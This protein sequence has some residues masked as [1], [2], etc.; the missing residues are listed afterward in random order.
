MGPDGP[1]WC[2]QGSGT[3]DVSRQKPRDVGAEEGKETFGET[4]VR[5]DQ[6]NQL[7][8]TCHRA[9]GFDLDLIC[10]HHSGPRH[11]MAASKAG[12][13][14]APDNAPKRSQIPSC[15][16]GGYTCCTNRVRDSSRESSMVAGVHEQTH[17]PD[18]QDQEL[19][20]L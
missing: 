14:S 15:A 11:E 13:M 18:L 4:V 17:I 5:Q 3:D 16:R 20:S 7:C 9:R 6:E 2:L 19:A 12:Y 10:E 8:N 1:R